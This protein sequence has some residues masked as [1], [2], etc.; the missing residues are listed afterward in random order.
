MLLREQTLEVL[1]GYQKLSAS[2]FDLTKLLP[3]V[4]TSGDLPENLLLVLSL[5]WVAPVGTLKWHHPVSMYVLL[6]TVYK[7]TC[8]SYGFL[9]LQCVTWSFCCVEN[10]LSSLMHIMYLE[11]NNI[12]VVASRVVK[13]VRKSAN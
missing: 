11:S 13:K 5:L 1:C 7:A 8:Y 6:N 10:H 2:G 3:S 12:A 4:I 9:Y